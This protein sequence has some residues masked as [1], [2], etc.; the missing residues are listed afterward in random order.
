LQRAQKADPAAV[1]MPAA[2]IVAALSAA[3]TEV[4]LLRERREQLESEAIALVREAHEAYREAAQAGRD[5][6][7]SE[8]AQ[9]QERVAVEAK[10][11]RRVFG[12]TKDPLLR[13]LVGLL[14][15]L[16]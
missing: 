14:R 7:K 4:R 5:A 11:L 9:R 8:K 3:R 1:D 16:V 12:R 13:E 10:E 2:D 15:G 6:A